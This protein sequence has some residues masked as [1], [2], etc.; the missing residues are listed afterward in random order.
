MADEKIDD[1]LDDGLMDIFSDE[2]DVDSDLSD[3]TGDLGDVVTTDLLAL[4]Q[5]VLTELR[6]RRAELEL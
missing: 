3:L 6:T 2:S 4:A 1:L 5:Q